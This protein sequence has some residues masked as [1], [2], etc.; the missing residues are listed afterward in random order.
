MLKTLTSLAAMAIIALVASRANAA[1][2]TFDTGNLTPFDNIHFATDSTP[3]TFRT[4]DIPGTSPLVLVNFSSPS[5][6][7]KAMT[8]SGLATIEGVDGTLT[9]LDILMTTPNATFTGFDFG[10]AVD[11]PS[12]DG[13]NGKKEKTSPQ[14]KLEA[15]LGGVLQGSATVSV[16]SGDEHFRIERTD[17]GRLDEIRI[18]A[19]GD[20]T[21]SDLIT[22]FKQPRI[23]AANG[24]YPPVSA[25]LPA[26]MW[27]GL[28]LMAAMGIKRLAWKR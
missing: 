7:L 6:N 17:G 9:S 10:I 24:Y 16:K 23:T 21:T 3:A 14:L 1:T 25:P 28:G 18:T 20:R 11:I 26:A 13:Q 5:E 12:I 8:G 22:M 27:G 19:I 15:F 2:V 4:G